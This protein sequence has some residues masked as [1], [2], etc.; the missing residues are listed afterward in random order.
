M[1]GAI[2]ALDGTHFD[3]AAPVRRVEA[4]I[5]PPGGAAAMYYTGP[6][7]GLQPTRPHLVPG[8]R[9]DAL[10][11][12]ERDVDG[13]PRGCARPSPPGGPGGAAARP[14]VALPAPRLDLR[15]RRGLGPLR[16][17]ADG[18]ARLPGPPRVPH[19]DA[20][21]PGAAGRPRHHRHRDAPRASRSRRR[22]PGP[23]PPFH[24]GERGRRSWAG[25]SSTPR[26][27]HPESFMASEIVRYLGWP[28]QAISYKVGE[29]VWLEARAGSPAPATA[30]PSTSRRSTPTPSTSVHSA[31]TGYEMSWP[32]SEPARGRR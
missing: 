24:P 2:D 21:R 23:E 31:S 6:V 30:A 28:G 15:A 19:G 22:P 16:R 4:M 11:A 10:P 18:R 5:A 1:D 29:R 3:I 7:G 14:A 25:R 32:T 13:L 27:R 8:Q 12:V 26:S 9:G 17:A 20:G